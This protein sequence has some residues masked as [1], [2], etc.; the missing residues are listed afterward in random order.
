[1][2]VSKMLQTARVDTTIDPNKLGIRAF[3]QK[4]NGGAK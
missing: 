4:H 3:K 2:N 1:M